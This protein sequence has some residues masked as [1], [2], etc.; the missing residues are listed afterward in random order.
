MSVVVLLIIILIGAVLFYF[1]LYN[2]Y[3]NIKMYDEYRAVYKDSLGNHVVVIEK[4]LFTVTVAQLGD[5]PY[6]MTIFEFIAN[7]NIV[8]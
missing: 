8:E 1:T 4:N 7:Y 5:E 3:K 6:T 2:E